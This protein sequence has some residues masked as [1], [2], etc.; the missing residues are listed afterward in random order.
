M[1]DTEKGADLTTASKSL[2]LIIEGKNFDWGKQYIT[3]R[4][5]RDLVNAS[6]EV[7]LFLAIKKPWEDELILDEDRVDLARPG[8]EKFFFKDILLLTI[9]D[10]KYKWYEQYITGKQLK[11]LAQISLEDVLYLSIKKP[12][13]DELIDNETS[14]DLARPGIEHFFS[15]QVDREIMIIVNGKLKSWNKRKISF[16]E[17]ISLAEGNASSEQKAYTVTYLKGPKQNSEGEMAKGDIVFV[18][19]KMIFNATPT[20]KS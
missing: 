4:E 9:N 1:K 8:I 7:E 14:V 16:E 18:T 15:K 2:P 10:K 5:V 6:E 19:D 11:E 17:V 20:D 13:K 12:W 3:G